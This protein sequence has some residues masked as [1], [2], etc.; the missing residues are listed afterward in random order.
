MYIHS[1]PGHSTSWCI[2]YPLTCPFYSTNGIDPS[3][4]LT[5]RYPLNPA[6]DFTFE[7]IENL[8][9]EAINP[10]N[11]MFFDKFIH[12]GGDEVNPYCWGRDPTI[13]QWMK[14]NKYNTYDAIHY[15]IT[16]VET[17][18]KKYNLTVL[19][20]DDSSYYGASKDTIIISYYNYPIAQI[21][22]EGYHAMASP[23]SNW[24][25]D[26]L[27]VEW[28]MFYQYEMCENITT[29]AKCDEYVLGGEISMWG[30]S[31]DDSDMDQ[32]IWP[33]AAAGAEK[34]WSQRSQTVGN[35]NNAHP[36]LE[37]F[38]CLLNQR[39]IAAAPTNNAAARQPPNGPSSC[40]Y[41]RR[42]TR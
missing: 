22:E 4:N 6:V 25:L 20:W 24:Y 42:R 39:G 3:T 7:F 18:A 9:A 28:P 41:Q 2:G 34:L 15:F 21:V 23:E 1:V 11:N 8:I 16:K 35:E 30:E 31:V 26:H 10:D 37:Y 5:C 32:T 36:R 19:Q 40:Y 38:R 13:E 17:I 29:Q 12:L 27:D 33:R 14:D